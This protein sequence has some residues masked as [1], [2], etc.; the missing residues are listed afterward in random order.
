MSQNKELA[1]IKARIKALTEKTVDAGCTEEEAL[2][3]AE[4]VG[5]LLS[6]YSLTMD[7]IDVREAKCVTVT[8]STGEAK[9]HPIGWCCVSLASFADCKVWHSR[10]KGSFEQTG[11]WSDSKYRR[12]DVVFKF[13]GQESDIDCVRYLFRVIF[14]AMETEVFKYK[15][16]PHYRQSS[17][18]RSASH[19][20]LQGMASRISDRLWNMKRENEASLRRAHEE[21]MQAAST[22]VDAHV[23]AAHNY[24]EHERK[25]SS[26]K[27]T[28]L[29]VLKKQLVEQEFKEQIGLKLVTRRSN[30]RVGDWKS[31]TS[32]QSAGDRV[33]LN[34]PIEGNSGPKGYLE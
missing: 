5:E 14:E 7:E 3:A 17:T 19:S 29:V 8:F 18:R 2:A 4:K 9:T 31:Y 24:T 21:R 34:R 20:F 27:G 28:A 33:N 6:Q 32:G 10:D 11:R 1:K 26:I 30:T 22:V 16:T 15:S 25:A 12:G 13:F 23:A